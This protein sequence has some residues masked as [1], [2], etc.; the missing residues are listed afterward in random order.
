[1]KELALAFCTCFSIVSIRLSY[2]I[3]NA[4]KINPI[5]LS[6]KM[7]GETFGVLNETG[8]V[9]NT[10]FKRVDKKEEID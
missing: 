8:F 9:V 5:L 7:Q 4:I 1:M 3:G 10:V 6:A 2:Q